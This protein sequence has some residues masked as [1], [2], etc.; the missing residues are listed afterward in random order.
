MKQYDIHCVDCSKKLTEKTKF[1]RPLEPITEEGPN[2]YEVVCFDCVQ[3]ARM[4]ET[5]D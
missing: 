4:N 3:E 5:Q 2:V 1:R